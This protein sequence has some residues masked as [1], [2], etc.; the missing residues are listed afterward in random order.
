MKIMA[1][2]LVIAASAFA[3]PQPAIRAETKGA[4]SPANTGNNNTFNIT[5]GIGRAQ[6]DQMIKILNTIL[7]N[8]LDTGAVLE[9]IQPRYLTDAQERRIADAIRPYGGPDV[10][11]LIGSHWNDPESTRLAR[12][13]KAALISGGIGSGPDQPVD[14]IG[15]F[16]QIP[17][18]LWGGG[19]IEGT[20]MHEGIEV[21]GSNA[22]AIAEALRSIG[23]FDATA[24]PA[25]K[26]P[27]GFWMKDLV[28][29]LVGVKPLLRP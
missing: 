15:K 13:V 20:E 8:Q 4:C 29:I 17:V 22:G 16:P 14:L 25:S 5:C 1:S 23:K 3:Q 9:L 21:W 6:G 26:Y 27:F 18:G 11:L 2:L 19:I 12:Q 24:P 10:P 28:A 7:A